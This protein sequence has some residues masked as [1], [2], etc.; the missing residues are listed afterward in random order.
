MSN[1]QTKKKKSDMNTFRSND[2]IDEFLTSVSDRFGGCGK[3]AAT[4]AVLE[5]ARKRYQ[6]QNRQNQELDLFPLT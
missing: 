1:V 2:L 6:S 5:S 3:S 4:R